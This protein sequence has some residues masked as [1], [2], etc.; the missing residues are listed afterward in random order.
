MWFGKKNKNIGSE[1]FNSAVDIYNRYRYQSNITEKHYIDPLEYEYNRTMVSCTNCIFSYGLEKCIVF[2]EKGHTDSE[3]NGIMRKVSFD[4]NYCDYFL[5]ENFSEGD[6]ED[7][8]AKEAC[9]EISR[10]VY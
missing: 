1:H 6:N 8:I 10:R 5:I 2:K 7:E 4:T 3:I 9:N